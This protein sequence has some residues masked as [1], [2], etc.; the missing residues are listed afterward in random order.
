ML[1]IHTWLESLQFNI[2]KGALN[3]TKS[4]KP[5]RVY[6]INSM[7]ADRIFEFLMVPLGTP[8]PVASAG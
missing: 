1:Y 5:L 2:A 7:T 4:V 8:I 6:D 3:Y